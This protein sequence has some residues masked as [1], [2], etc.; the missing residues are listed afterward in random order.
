MRGMGLDIDERAG[1]SSQRSNRHDKSQADR[2]ATGGDDIVGHPTSSSGDDGKRA[3]H[4]K[5]HT[6]NYGNGI[7][8]LA[9]DMAN[10]DGESD[11]DTQEGADNKD[12]APC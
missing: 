7:D 6:H 12:G 2:P 1:Q 5:T 11:N 4:D 3:T 10:D 9:V 8:V